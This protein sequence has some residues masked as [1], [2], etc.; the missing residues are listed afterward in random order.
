MQRKLKWAKARVGSGNFGPW[1]EGQGNS[2]KHLKVESRL[3]NYLSVL[4]CP[5]FLID[6]PFLSESPQFSS[7]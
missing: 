2:K 1:P 7:F 6:V 4:S 5:R 3:L